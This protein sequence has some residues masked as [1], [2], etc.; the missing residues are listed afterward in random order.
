MRRL[1][2][3]LLAL[4][5]FATVQAQDALQSH[6]AS[7]YSRLDYTPP[8]NTGRFLMNAVASTVDPSPYD[9]RNQ[10][11]ALTGDEWWNVY[12]QLSRGSKSTTSPLPSVE[13][14]AGRVAT[15]GGTGHIPLGL[16][17]WNYNYVEPESFDDQRV[18]LD[19]Q[20]FFRPTD[21]KGKRLNESTPFGF[22]RLFA[23]SALRAP[24]TTGPLPLAVSFV[25]PSD[26]VFVS[27]EMQLVS[28]EVKFTGGVS[29]QPIAL[30]TP[31]S[32]TYS[33]ESSHEV[34]IRANI[35]DRG[36]A[37]TVKA[38][39]AIDVA[40][41]SAQAFSGEAPG[42]ESGDLYDGEVF[43]G[44]GT[45]SGP[46][47]YDG[48]L[49]AGYRYG[50]YYANP[51]QQLRKP[52]I[53]V[54]GYD[55][56]EDRGVREIYNQYLDRDDGGG[57]LADN[58]RAQGY[59]VVVLDWVD[60]KDFIQRNG[61]ALVKLIE[62]LNA[63]IASTGNPIQAVVGVSMG[64]L[65]ARYSLLRMEAEGRDHNVHAF[66][67]FDGAQQGGNVPLGLQ[68]HIGHV[69]GFLSWGP[70]PGPGDYSEDL[71]R[72]GTRQLLMVNRDHGM[73][74][75]LRD[76]LYE[77]IWALGDYPDDV[78]RVAIV[79][80]SG[81]GDTQFRSA[82]HEAQGGGSSSSAYR[83]DPGEQYANQTFRVTVH[84]V[85]VALEINHWAVPN[86]ARSLVE[87]NVTR[88][89]APWPVGCAAILDRNEY[90]SPSNVLPF[91]GAPGGWRGSQGSLDDNDIYLRIRSFHAS[92]ET[93]L[94][95]E[96]H[97]FI[98]SVSALDYATSGQSRQSLMQGL[99]LTQNVL[100][101]ISSDSPAQRLARTPFDAFY[102]PGVTASTDGRNQEHIAASDPTIGS[103]FFQQLTLPVPDR[104]PTPL[105][106]SISG[107][108]S[109]DKGVSATW[110]ASAANG[111]A[112]YQFAW[113]YYYNCT[114]P[115]P[116]PPSPCSGN[117]CTELQAS[118]RGEDTSSLAPDD[119]GHC[120][121]WN[122]G[123]TSSSFTQTFWKTPQV[124]IRVTA[125]DAVGE[126][127][128][129]TRS[130]SV[131]HDD[132]LVA[133][134]AAEAPAATSVSAPLAA[135]ALPLDFA[136]A[137]P[138]PNPFSSTAQVAFD[139]PEASEVRL[140]VYDVLGR[141]VAVLAEGWHEAGRYTPTFDGGRLPSGTYL[142]RIQAG[143]F[144][145]T[146]S[147]TLSR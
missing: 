48:C 106:A 134:R 33:S 12:D 88:G 145:A 36:S 129:K 6:I 117:T 42:F 115:P 75:P 144:G 10:A 85:G 112:P 100:Y 5:P 53:V 93:N 95:A 17:L 109:V 34:V 108:T 56:D 82:L 113:S 78:R 146:R 72:P 120:G 43:C 31:V 70:G 133:G 52:I 139:L 138:R 124:Q 91:D 50:I 60:S 23:S 64:G 37:R 127:A 15:W 77:E 49:S 141:E 51:D 40:P 119:P 67:S 111:T 123:G 89:C 99:F 47:N 45:T 81:T 28:M 79:N 4:I 66:V 69:P 125:T 80:G 110:G 9:G 20:G 25:V 21:A 7:V 107:P 83:V 32:Y 71:R 116:P 24:G 101:D 128:T 11:P 27:P 61:L 86:R 38:R 94:Y 118:T 55:V 105:T 102:L 59:D 137:A 8:A 19:T 44:T 122:N 46:G 58:L 90:F 54:D 16:M 65:V 74:D 62:T 136:L 104:T 57:S 140:A 132:E 63:Q 35:I 147:T 68:Y 121:I 26:L 2:L 1:V 76:A 3:A 131:I 92:V 14:V 30:D 135:A 126:T 114:S 103:F 87:E 29:F 39:F 142:V 97:N 18:A 98:S 73:A 143:P 130:V 13:A 41:A 22:Q 84:G 96:R